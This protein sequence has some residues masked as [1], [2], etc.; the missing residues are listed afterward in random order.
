MM[1]LPVRWNLLI[2]VEIGF[3][4]RGAAYPLL[5]LSCLFSEEA[6]RFLEQRTQ[7][8]NISKPWINGSSLPERR[9][10]RH[11]WLPILEKSQLPGYYICTWYCSVRMRIETGTVLDF[12]EHSSAQNR[13]CRFE[14]YLTGPKRMDIWPR[15]IRS[16][17]LRTIAWVIWCFTALNTIHS[18]RLCIMHILM[19]LSPS[20]MLPFRQI[21]DRW[22]R[23][24]RG[25]S[26]PS[27][28]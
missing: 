22:G 23:S 7:T 17:E 2:N 20:I 11:A 14:C 8:G 21:E 25:P 1:F 12:T 18:A 19:T 6:Y 15:L 5:E 27:P 4:V 24:D 10:L 28:W 26:S 16:P 3:S 9:T 13:A